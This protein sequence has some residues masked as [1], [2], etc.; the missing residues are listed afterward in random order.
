MILMYSVV[1]SGMPVMTTSLIISLVLGKYC[2][3]SRKALR[4]QS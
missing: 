2:L 1:A 3:A 4:I